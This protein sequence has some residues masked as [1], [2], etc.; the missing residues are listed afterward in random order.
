MA[1][2]KHSLSRL[3]WG[4]HEK[5]QLE[6][7]NF[8]HKLV[9]RYVNDDPYY[10]KLTQEG[11]V[12]YEQSFLAFL[13]FLEKTKNLELLRRKEDLAIIE[14]VDVFHL[15]QAKEIM[16]ELDKFLKK[17]QNKAGPRQILWPPVW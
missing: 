16:A 8:K 6:L 15:K 2:V 5:R 17:Q 4:Q 14:K 9:E 13:D 10:K 1:A 12:Y 11:Q 3:I 7:C